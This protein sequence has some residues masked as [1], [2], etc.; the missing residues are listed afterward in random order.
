MTLRPL[1]FLALAALFGCEEATTL[2]PLSPASFDVV[3]QPTA[4]ELSAAP[5][6][7]DE[8]GGGVFID[9]AGGV[10]RVRPNGDRGVLEPHPRNATSPGPASGVFGLGPSNALVATSRGLFV[11]DQGWLIAPSWQDVLP[12]DGVKA[13]TIA[14]TGVAWVVHTQGL[15]QLDHGVLTE[16]KVRDASLTGL[17]APTLDGTPGIW[18]AHDG[19]LFAAAQTGKTDFTVR[20]SGLSAATLAGGVTAMVG[21]TPSRDT[22]GELWAITK[23]SLLLYT[24][25]SWR[26]YTLRAAPRRLV[27]AGRFAWLQAGDAIYRYDADTRA[28]AEAKGLDAAGTLLSADAAGNA[29]L[30]VGTQ[31]LSISPAV[32]PRVRGLFQDAKIYDGQLIIEAALPS[33][34]MPET[35]T[36]DLDGAATATLDPTKAVVGAGPTAGL[37]LLSLGGADASGALKPVTLS[38]LADGWHT[39]TVSATTGERTTS[40]RVYFEFL[41]SASASVSWDRDI[42][43]LGVARCSKCH[44]TGTDPELITYAQWKANAAAIAAAVRDS[45]MPADGPLDSAGVAAIVRWVNGG[46][47]P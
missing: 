42:R 41:G 7:A 25:V 14:A 18:F 24:G 46:E 36:W 20:E 32:T 21:I 33:A 5:S 27:G 44:A 1:T 3:T 29:W 8:R 2:E 6:F 13:T 47:Q 26:Q 9:L 35:L 19:K 30:R 34:E 17:T 45:R 37:R 15:F 11:A 22:G 16:F 39:L 12:A 28:W 23:E 10:V 31:T 38:K 40:R 43:E 4:L